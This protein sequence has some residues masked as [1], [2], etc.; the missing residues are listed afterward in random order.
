MYTCIYMYV[1]MYTFIY[2]ESKCIHSISNCSYAHCANS[3]ASVT[4]RSNGS[5]AQPAFSCCTTSAT[6]SLSPPPALTATITYTT[7]NS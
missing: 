5:R 7:T 1:Y 6:V 3:N 4:A 2:R